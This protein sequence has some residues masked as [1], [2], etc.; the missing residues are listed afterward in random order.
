MKDSVGVEV[1]PSQVF[2]DTN[3]EI[4]PE[5]NSVLKYFI[6]ESSG[7]KVCDVKQNSASFP[8]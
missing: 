5:I 2:L 6:L 3:L 1:I 7:V 4:Y 8:Q